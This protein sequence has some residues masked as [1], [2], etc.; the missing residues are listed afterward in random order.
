M[1]GVVLLIAAVLLVLASTELVLRWIDVADPPTFQANALFGYLMRPNQSAS[2]RG[3]RFRINNVGLRGADVN[4]RQLGERR[5][6]FIGD[7]ITYAGGKVPD[8]DLFATRVSETLSALRRERVTAINISAPGWGIQNMA[9][10]IG[11]TGV[12]EADVVVWVIPSTDF[13]RRMTFLHDYAYPQTRPSSRLLYAAISWMAAAH[14]RDRRERTPEEY[15]AVPGA[16]VLEAN[17]ATLDAALRALRVLDLPLIVAVLADSAGYRD[18]AKDVGRF[19]SVADANGAAFVDL[20]PTFGM[21]N[22]APLFHDG[23]HLNSRGHELVTHALVTTVS[24]AL[25]KRG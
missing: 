23:V 19:K 14:N 11:A 6:A 16:D 2:T 20:E 4:A 3:H 24:A 15:S 21:Q 18:L 7:S 25:A 1:T 13:R 22:D 12:F 8:A 5:V 17:L 9:A 10:F